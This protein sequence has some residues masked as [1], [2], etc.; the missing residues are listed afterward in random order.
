MT[1]GP[2][3]DCRAKR[4]CGPRDLNRHFGVQAGQVARTADGRSLRGGECRWPPEP[5]VQLLRRPVTA[6]PGKVP[7]DPLAGFDLASLAES[8]AASA[9]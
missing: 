4:T 3:A 6:V 2:I 5:A 7:L 9:L 8:L 1:W